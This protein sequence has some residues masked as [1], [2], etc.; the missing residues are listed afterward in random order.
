MQR[1]IVSLWFPR[2]SS[3]RMQRLQPVEGPFVLTERQSNAERVA[4][5]NTEAE[6]KGLSRGMGFSDARAYCPDVRSAPVDRL[7]DQRFLAA[8]LRW[9]RK[10]SPWVGFEGDNGLVLDITGV[11]HLFGGEAGMLADMRMRLLR[12]RLEVR[13]GL[14]DTRGAAWA[15]ARFGEGVAPEGDT[16]GA[17]ADLPV[18][19]LR[20][21]SKTCVGLE[22]L[23]IRTIAALRNLPRAT[24]TRRFGNDA[25]LR[26]DQALGDR[27]EE[28]TPEAEAAPLAVRLTFPEPIGLRGD[29]MAGAGRLLEQLCQRLKD[30]DLG[31]RRL[32]VTLQRVDKGSQQVELR[33]ARPLRDAATI[34]PLFERG[35]SEVDAGFGIDLMRMQAT[36]IESM[37]ARQLGHI[38]SRSK[39]GLSDLITR[40]GSRIGLDNIHRMLPADSHIPERSFLIAAAAY[41]DG[42]GSW[43]VAR[44][45][46]VVLFPP[47]GVAATGRRPPQ[48]FKWRRMRLTAA[49][50]SGPERVAPEWWLP[51]DNWRTGLRDYWRVETRQGR[52]LWMYH[53]P[54]APGWYVQGEFA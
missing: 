45:R 6:A 38:Q 27:S 35:L 2:L 20:L 48:H 5:L 22:R 16:G 1:R 47:E 26:L 40:L 11:A 10:Y 23:G 15:L 53:T 8:L 41:S 25:L 13:I 32:E 31:V 39:D 37:P 54:Q 7:Q 50:V 18:A 34:L 12:A 30:R 36:Q 33:L 49:Q 4:C 19:A 42:A 21:D 51:D 29:V 17:L 3:D 43:P 46:P 28:I 9:A 44:P 24:V 52:R 14:A